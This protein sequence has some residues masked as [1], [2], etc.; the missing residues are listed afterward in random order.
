MTRTLSHVSLIANICY[1]YYSFPNH[2]TNIYPFLRQSRTIISPLL[3]RTHSLV[4]LCGTSS[5]KQMSS[6]IRG[7]EYLLPFCLWREY[8]IMCSN[9]SLWLLKVPPSQKSAFKMSSDIHWSSHNHFFL[10]FFLIIVQ[11][12]LKLISNHIHAHVLMHSL[13]LP[14]PVQYSKNFSISGYRTTPLHPIF[15]KLMLSPNYS[16]SLEYHL[17]LRIRWLK[18]KYIPYHPI[19][20]NRMLLTDPNIIIV[21][22]IHKSNQIS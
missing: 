1:A 18:F 3:L 16:I 8:V 11:T 14:D 6:R 5:I 17:L 21:Q 9:S 12:S 15:F 22:H 7:L 10:L 2:P 19:I 20:I 13:L 4:S